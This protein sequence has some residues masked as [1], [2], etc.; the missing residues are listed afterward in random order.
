MPPI[1][2]NRARQYC[3]TINNYTDDDLAQCQTYFQSAKNWIIGREVGESNTPHL[4]CYVQFHSAKD[5]SVIKKALPKAHIEK[6]KGSLK[7]NY[8]YCSKDGN[9]ETNIDLRTNQQKLIDLCM[10]EYK[11][12]KWKPWQK[13]IID[14]LDKKPDAR[15]IN[16][17]WEDTGNVGKSYLCKYLAMTKNVIICDGKKDNIFNQV[18]VLIDKD[19]YPTIILLDVPRTN[20]DY[21]NYGAIEQLKNGLIYSGKYEGGQCIFPIPH[22]IAFANE[23]PDYES[24]SKDR[25]VVKKI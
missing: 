13:E 23:R 19:K 8:E 7:Q 15:T 12:V 18:K 25:W 5:F 10:D 9:Y 24:M 20:L 14:M 2:R 3:I 16:W 22:V 11:D 1:K 6:A 4:Q 17:Y 21:I